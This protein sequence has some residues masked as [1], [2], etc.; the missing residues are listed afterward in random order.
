MGQLSSALI[1]EIEAICRQ[2]K[3]AATPAAEKERLYKR[4]EEIYEAY[5]ILRKE[6]KA[7]NQGS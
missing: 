5:F 7:D 1:D 4:L 2:I 3:D 6:A